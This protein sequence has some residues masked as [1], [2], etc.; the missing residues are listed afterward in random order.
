MCAFDWVA[1]NVKERIDLIKKMY[2]ET[3]ELS[4][5]QIIPEIEEIEYTIRDA[6]SSLHNKK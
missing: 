2:K 1:Q 3:N 6:Q 5:N 4:K